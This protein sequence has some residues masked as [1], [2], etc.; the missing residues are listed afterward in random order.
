VARVRAVSLPRLFTY[1]GY[2]AELT[3]KDLDELE[4]GEIVPKHVQP[5]DSIEHMADLTRVGQAA[6]QTQVRRA[7]FERFV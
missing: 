5:L 4:L 6:G 7:H 1:M 3:R 2:N